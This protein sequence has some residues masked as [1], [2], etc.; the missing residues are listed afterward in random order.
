V[1]DRPELCVGAIV[2]DGDRILLVRRG[3]GSGVGLWSVPGGRVER[4]ETLAAA[5]V[6]ELAEETGLVGTCEALV[7]IA[8]R[9]VDGAHYVILDYRVRVASAQEPRAGDDAADVRWF[10]VS[11]LADLD[12]RGRL[13]PGLLTFLGEHDVGAISDPSTPAGAS[14]ERR[15][16]PP[17][18][19]PRGSRSTSPRR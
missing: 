10:G 7:G 4:G 17:A 19:P 12:A 6:R 13:V 3:R 9:I 1:T 15:A 14:P 2:V 8:E 16:D 11:Q 5:V 18:D